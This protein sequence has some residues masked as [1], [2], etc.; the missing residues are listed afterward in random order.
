MGYTV[1]VAPELMV[2]VA[3]ADF[4]VSATLVAV[5]LTEDEFS[6]LAGAVY[7]PCVVTVPTVALPPVTLFTDQVTL[8]LSFPVTV[9]VNCCVACNFTVAVVGVI[10]TATVFEPPP[11]A[12]TAADNNSDTRQVSFPEFFDSARPRASAG[13]KCFSPLKRSADRKFESGSPLV[14]INRLRSFQKIVQ[15]RSDLQVVNAGRQRIF[16]G[17]A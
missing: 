10:V 1:T 12:M 6:A 16:K 5:T 11:Q 8:V 14:E 15:I 17:I 7:S 9:A 13:M 4:E 3:E 2:T